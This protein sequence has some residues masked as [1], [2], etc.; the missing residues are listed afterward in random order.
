MGQRVGGGSMA[1]WRRTAIR[2]IERSRAATLRVLAK[3]PEREILRPRTMSKWSIKDVLA[4]IIAWEEE[5][6]K[7][8]ALIASR[9]GDRMVYYEG[10]EAAE[11]FNAR[12]VA[13]ARRLS[14][15]ALL[16]R[17]V[18]VRQKLLTGLEKLPAT[19]LSDPA[20]GY[21]PTEWLLEFACTHEQG[22]LARI[23]AWR[24]EQRAMR[25][26]QWANDQCGNSGS[27]PTQAAHG[28]RLTAFPRGCQSCTRRRSATPT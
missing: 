9:R 20:K 18:G 15:P 16:R 6:A 3:I 23:K 13:A 22:H 1:A 19:W 2:R 7:R 27:G 8:L 14:W 17:A 11:K 28:Q 4:H 12:A 5:A 25:N 26:D 21:P 10:L 24:K